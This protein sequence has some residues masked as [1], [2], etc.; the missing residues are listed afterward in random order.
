METKRILVVLPHPDD[1]VFPMSGTLARYIHEGSQVTYLCLTLG[2]M[3]RNLGNPPFANRITL[4]EVRRKELEASCKVIGIQDLRLL[5]YHDKTI[6]FEP[7]GPLDERLLGIIREVRPDLIFTFYPG[8]GVHPDHNACGAA[9]IRTVAGMPAAERPVVL[10]SAFP[11]DNDLGKPEVVNDIRPFMHQKL[12]ALKAHS[13][14]FQ[15]FGV[16][17]NATEEDAAL[18][19]RIGTEQFWIYPF[20]DSEK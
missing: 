2:E 5:G 11:T 16:D 15:L 1:E 8:Y 18:R 14:Q 9:V 10:C 17:G 3:G 12:G 19:K 6:E 13:S 20:K 4:P 7:Y